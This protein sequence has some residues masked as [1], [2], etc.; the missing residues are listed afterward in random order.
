MTEFN[1][2][3][4]QDR[5]SLVENMIAEGRRTTESWGWTFVFWGIAYLVAMAW[6]SG[7][8]SRLWPGR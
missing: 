2:Q 6:S 1:S 8:Q 5:F 3:E 7:D 4:L